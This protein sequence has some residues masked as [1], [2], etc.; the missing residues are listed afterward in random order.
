MATVIRL[1]RGG[2]KKSPF[3][4]IV[5]TD[6]RS[7]RDGNFIEKLGTFNPMV[8]KEN[9]LRLT[10]NAERAKHWLSVGALPSERVQ[11]L[12][13]ELGLVEAPSF[14]GKPE[15]SRRKPDKLTRREKAEKAL[16]EAEAA[17]AA[18]AEAAAAGEGEAA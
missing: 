7:P 8:E 18:E 12:F 2:S 13:A 5:A 16:K 10:V 4:R 17:K 11:K 14:A 6:K 15:K 3:Y 1:A 9:P